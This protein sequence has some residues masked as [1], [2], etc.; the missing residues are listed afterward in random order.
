MDEDKLLISVLSGK[1]NLNCT[2][3]HDNGFVL[4]ISAKSLPHL[5]APP[6]RDW[7]FFCKIFQKKYLEKK[8][9]S[10]SSIRLA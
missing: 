10:E 8:L 1:F 9:C 7:T 4:R 5:Q 2:I 3:Q 6:Y